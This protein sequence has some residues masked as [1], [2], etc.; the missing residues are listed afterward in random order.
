MSQTISYQ[1]PQAAPAIPPHVLRHATR[2]ASRL[3]RL[4]ADAGDL[5]LAQVQAKNARAARRQ[6][7]D[8]RR[9]PRA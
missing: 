4:S 7:R 1:F 2:S 6:L 8:R 3:A 5:D 9:A